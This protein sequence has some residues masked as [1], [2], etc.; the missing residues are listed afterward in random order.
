MGRFR[1]VEHHRTEAVGNQDEEAHSCVRLQQHPGPRGARAGP[2]A[3][4]HVHRHHQLP[5]SASP[6]LRGRRQRDRRGHGRASPTR[7]SSRSTPTARSACS[8]TAAA[9][10][11]SRSPGAKDRRPAVEVVLTVLHAGGKFGGGGYAISGGLHGV[12][13]SVVNA[14]S[15]EARGRGHARR[16]LVDTRRS[17]AA[18]PRSKLTKGKATTKTGTLVRFWPDPEI[19]TE[20]LEFKREILAERLHELAFL[21]KGVEIQLIDERETPKTRRLQGQRRPRRLREVPRAGQGRRRTAS[22]PSRPD[23]PT[24]ARSRS[25]CSG[26]TATPSRSTRSRTRSTRTRAACTR[27]A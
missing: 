4:G 10:R 7:S 25:R 6:R 20:T 14:L 23:A 2:Q 13:V 19:F 15:R 26:T 18:R 12:G 16:L 22:S 8:T 9:S 27:R 1:R 11:S 24:T 5:R 3:A 21:N 17:S